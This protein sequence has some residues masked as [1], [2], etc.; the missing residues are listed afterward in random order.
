MK[1]ERRVFF[2]QARFF[3]TI[4]QGTYVRINKTVIYGQVEDI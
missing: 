2:P 1:Q 4:L 3:M